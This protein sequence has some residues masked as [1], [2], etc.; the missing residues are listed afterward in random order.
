MHQHPTLRIVSVGL[1]GNCQVWRVRI[2]LVCPQIHSQVI[3]NEENS[4]IT[5]IKIIN[6]IFVP[7]QQHLLQIFYVINPVNKKL[8]VRS[9]ILYDLSENILMRK[10]QMLPL[11]L[12]NFPL[13]KHF[14]KL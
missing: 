12:H 4:E 8:I 11:N 7:V 5:I 1:M 9:Q 10:R 2:I 6:A 13:V 14:S 3:G